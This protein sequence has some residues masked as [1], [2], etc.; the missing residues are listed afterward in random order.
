MK[1]VHLWSN[2]VNVW[3][4]E[5]SSGIKLSHNELLGDTSYCSN[6]IRIILSYPHCY[7]KWNKPGTEKTNHNLTYMWN[8]KR[9]SQ[10]HRRRKQGGVKK[11]V[12][13][14][15]IDF[16]RDWSKNIKCQINAMDNL[17]RSIVQHDNCVLYTW[18][19]IT[20]LYIWKLPTSY[21]CVSFWVSCHTWKTW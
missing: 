9:R 16:G 13:A 7:G 17:R 2:H 3:R 20:M 5:R 8:T 19:T 15:E 10:I 14:L 6:V 1:L 18:N 11:K 4:W 12:K 21:S